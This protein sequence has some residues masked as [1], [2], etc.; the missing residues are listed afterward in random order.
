MM[1]LPIVVQCYQR[2]VQ[3][4]LSLGHESEQT[5]FRMRKA[6]GQVE[7][8]EHADTFCLDPRVSRIRQKRLN[9][10]LDNIAAAGLNG[11]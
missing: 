5:N 7:I 9:D 3:C 6:S 11:D 4:T 1:R 10:P 8:G 2:P